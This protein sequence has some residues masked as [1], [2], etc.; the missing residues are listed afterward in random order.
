MTFLDDA[1]RRVLYASFAFTENSLAFEGGIK[2]I[3][4]AHGKI[5]RL[6]A[7]RRYALQ[8][9]GMDHGRLWLHGAAHR[10]DESLCPGAR[11]ECHLLLPRNDPVFRPRIYSEPPSHKA[12]SAA[13]PRRWRRLQNM[14]S[15]PGGRP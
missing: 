14:Q 7:A 11:S 8:P 4:K 15:L 13:G 1:T 10:R 3:L 5:G 2:H 12:A 9:A 6:Y